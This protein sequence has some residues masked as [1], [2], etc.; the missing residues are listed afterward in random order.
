MSVTAVATCIGV[1][2]YSPGKSGNVVVT[3]G[4]VISLCDI[5]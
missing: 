5:E 4:V 1:Y 2:K 3:F